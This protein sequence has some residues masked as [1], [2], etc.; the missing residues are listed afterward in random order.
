MSV[1]G[2]DDDDIDD[3]G[4]DPDSDDSDGA[5]PTGGAGGDSERTTTVA[6]AL[7]VAGRLLRDRPGRVLP[8][9][10][11]S[12][13]VATAARVPLLAG[14]GVAAWLLA[15]TGRLD[16]LLG[17][18]ADLA[19]AGALGEVPDGGTD[20][21]AAPGELPLPAD[22]LPPGTV[23]AV[24]AALTP[25]VVGAAMVGVLGAVAVGLLGRAVANA[26]AF[27]AVGAGVAGREPLVEGVACA[28]RWRTFL[29]LILVRAVAAL[30]GVGV[31]V[32][33]VALAVAGV[34]PGAGGDPVALAG[35][36]LLGLVGAAVGGLAV[37][38]VRL[39][40]LF[41]E[42]AAVVD[43]RRALPAVRASAGFVRDRPVSAVAFALVVVGS[44]VAVGSVAAAASVAG[45]GSL[46]GLVVPLVVAPVLDAA[47]V[48]LYRGVGDDPSAAGRVATADGGRATDGTAAGE[49]GLAARVRRA[50]RI[51]LSA[52]AG[53]V[54]ERPGA[55][56]ASAGALAAGTAAGYLATASL[57]V[58]VPPPTDVAG[59]FG[60]VPVG[61]FVQIA[62]N[63][64]L[65]SA[66][67]AYGGVA[68]GLPALAGLLFN[69]VVVGAIAGVF[70]P[71]ALLALVAPHGVLELPTIA[72]AGGLGL[73][74]G[75]VGWRALRGRAAAAEVADELALAGRVLVGVGVLL[76]VAAAIEAFLTPW[77]AAAVLE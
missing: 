64:W 66:G 57:G 71:V 25:G 54:R 53:F 8:A 47:A 44:Y 76:V 13:G 5:D 27:G 43:G 19:A 59:V 17:A 35:L 36:A 39:A 63:N 75:R 32:G 29:G 72:V 22:D 48:G 77:I 18:L 33:L 49:A 30:V 10:L 26:V 67:L 2:S 70:D 9:F 62:A 3:G 51:G 45:A 41:A 60:A 58:R 68:L 23:D 38:L 73:R 20:P 34:G 50:P 46:A 7:T 24:L 55:V 65:V 52:L 11:L 14:A 61:P 28:A 21:G 4:A 69:G 12:L 56:A 15:S 16:P 1:D 6:D 31:P 42:P 37:L 40:L 74:L